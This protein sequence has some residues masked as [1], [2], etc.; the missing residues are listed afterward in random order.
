MRQRKSRAFSWPSQILAQM[1]VTVPAIRYPIPC[2][3]SRVNRGAIGIRPPT[4]RRCLR[5]Q[6]S[7]DRGLRVRFEAEGRRRR[8]VG[9]GE[10]VDLA[11]EDGSDV[12]A[13]GLGRGGFAHDGG[14]VRLRAWVRGLVG[15]AAGEA[16]AW[17]GKEEGLR[18]NLRG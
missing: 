15:E 2:R 12:G 9:V 13:A 4:R 17:D 18:E 10:G 5:C 14:A 1:M 8:W 11:G 16:K 3:P 7:G 6:C